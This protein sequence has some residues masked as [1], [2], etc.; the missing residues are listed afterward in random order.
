MLIT[1]VRDRIFSLNVIICLPKKPDA[2]EPI[3]VVE[4]KNKKT[5]LDL[6]DFQ[7]LKIMRKI[8]T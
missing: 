7:D 8:A 5:L 1:G 3:R 6:N 4:I 2:K